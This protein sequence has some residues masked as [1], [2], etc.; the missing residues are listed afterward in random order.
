MLKIE[1][2][3]SSKNNEQ[4]ISVNTFNIVFIHKPPLNFIP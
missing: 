2:I 3:L 1:N 4:N